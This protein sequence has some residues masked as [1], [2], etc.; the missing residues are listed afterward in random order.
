MK[1]R[2]LILSLLISLLFASGCGGQS[3]IREP[4]PSVGIIRIKDP[5]CLKNVIVWSDDDKEIM[6]LDRGNQCEHTFF[7]SFPRPDYD[8]SLLGA[9]GEVNFPERYRDPF[10]ELADGWYLIDWAWHNVAN[11]PYP[12][13][14]YTILTEVTFANLYDYGTCIFDKSVPHIS[15]SRDELYETRRIYIADLMAY[16][17][18]DGN[19]PPIEHY[20]YIK[21][22]Q[23]EE[24]VS[25]PNQYFYHQGLYNAPIASNVVT[26]LCDMADEMDAYWALLQNQL[27]TLINNGDLNKIKHFDVNQLYIDQ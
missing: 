4:K 20:R 12:N 13:L 19:Y 11:N 6:T 3:G 16:I 9:T 2:L 10:W 8:G 7:Q 14:G 17:Y 26:C 23:K 15:R 24:L 25:Y 5:V 1:A 22:E 27:T 21:E 18:P